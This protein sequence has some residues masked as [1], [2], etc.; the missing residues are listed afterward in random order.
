MIKILNNIFYATVIIISHNCSEPVLKK[1]EYNQP[2]KINFCDSGLWINK[3]KITYFKKNNKFD[4]VLKV[5]EISRS[6]AEFY[7]YPKNSF[8]FIF[9][10]PNYDADIKFEIYGN[11][12][13]ILIFNITNIKIIEKGYGH[14]RHASLGSYSIN[15]I[16]SKEKFGTSIE[17]CSFLKNKI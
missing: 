13:S 7:F 15:N 5:Q 4:S 3:F 12:D 10:D 9:P 2:L 6:S 1:L 16:E 17:V 14:D 11:N 8:G